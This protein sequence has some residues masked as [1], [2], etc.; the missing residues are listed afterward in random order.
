MTGQA[1]ILQTTTNRIA[2]IPV[3]GQS[4]AQK[5]VE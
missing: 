2:E 3:K 4:D 5:P 1:K